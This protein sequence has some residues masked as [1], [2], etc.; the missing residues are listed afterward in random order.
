MS[1]ISLLDTLGHPLFF[2]TIDRL[3]VDE[4]EL[5]EPVDEMLQGEWV[6]QRRAVWF[7]C[8]PPPDRA[9]DL[10]A[11]GWKI[12][13]SSAVAN[14][15]DILKA[16]VPVLEARNV[17]FKFALDRRIL[18]MMN[19]KSWDRQGAGKFITIYPVDKAE[20][21][22]LLEELHA[23]TGGF[24]GIYILSDKRYADSKVLFYR[25][26]GIRPRNLA[27]E[28]G[29]E[30]SMLVSPTGEEVP[31]ERKPFFSPP[32]WERDPFEDQAEASGEFEDEQGRI[33]LKGGR[34]LVKNVLG[35][36]NSGGVYIAD[37]TETG[38]EVLIKEA[39][40]FV[41]FGEDATKLLEKEFRLLSKIA[42]A[43]EEIAP[44][45]IDFFQ[46]WE[47][48][49]LV[50]E[51]I[52]GVQLRAY[53]AM[54][55]VTLLTSPGVDD[56]E[57]YFA[58]FRQIFR[59]LARILQVLHGLDIVFSDLSPSNVL[60]LTDPLRVKIIDFEAAHEIG[61]DP[62]AR[63]FTLGFAYRDQMYG[64]SSRFES[65][66]FSLGALMH[67]YVAPFNQIFG[68]SPKSRFK[69]LQA[70]VD[71]LG[72]PK[73]VHETI[74]A[75]I[76][77]DVEARPKP[78]QVIEVLDRDYELRAP[79][80]RVDGE[81]D[82]PRYRREVDRIRDYILGV[83]DFDRQD[84]LFPAY[85]AVFH[86]NP[87]SLSYG[88]CGVAH[89]LQAMGHEVPE[90]VVD[91]I[92]QPTSDRDKYPP[93]L[94]VGLAGMAWTLLD[95]GRRATAE[96]VLAL[97]HAHPLRPASFDLFHGLAGC[98]LT[99]LK[100]FLELGDEAYLA[101]AVEAGEL[102]L[103]ASRS[104]AKGLSWEVGGKTALGLGHGASG[105][106]LF[107]LYL[108]LATGR[109]D[110][111]ALGARALDH[112][113][114]CAT[115]TRDGG[116]SWRRYDDDATI[117]Y[118]YWRYGSAGVGA[119]LVRYHAVLG[120]ERYAGQLEKVYRD[121]NRKYAVYPGLFVG[122]AG[123]GETLL[124]FHRFIGEERFGVAAHRI[125]TGLSLFQIEREE[126]L[127]FP[128]DG[129]TKICCDLATG[130]AGIGRFFSRLVTGAPA[131]LLLDA[132]LLADR[133]ARP[134]AGAPVPAEVGAMAAA[135][136]PS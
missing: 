74:V 128:G 24:E 132:A 108:H 71:D 126:G 78:E 52:Q 116:L 12:H 3:E 27:N 65:D 112:D 93:G 58:D 57:R 92:L 123:V 91:W 39:R 96:R 30:V 47:H 11:Q 101:K 22:L 109:E 53:S 98:G 34:Y 133:P 49:F 51:L 94:Y 136:A 60:I 59:Q 134:L 80:F 64:E 46:D 102:L 43:G 89:A 83:A 77:N 5:R 131:P 135:G 7:N 124:D 32:P 111:L 33:A 20:F 82:H 25:Y 1:R 121:L 18:E 56:M 55:N 106:S 62:P 31:D 113:L 28:R 38:E 10:P 110:F 29:E 105:I 66:Y 86:T 50:Q 42:E 23:V 84:R 6:F 100:F 90:R 35:F 17:S 122:L 4:G 41:T 85:G 72:F 36:T 40:P 118:P 69:F 125:A 88:A 117:I 8:T 79:A 99:D 130:S 81:A 44:R 114:E 45:P 15:L 104:S 16:V 107:L 26:G 48:H 87:L 76:D 9:R 68:I 127:A 63:L 19:S 75:L 54:H 70:I 2:E 95:L 115:P 67:Y 61:V 129:L 119:A 14:A 21:L 37:D 97:S 103:E 120:E 73:E 13:V